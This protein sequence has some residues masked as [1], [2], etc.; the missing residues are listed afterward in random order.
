[1]N[2]VPSIQR[3]KFIPNLVSYL[4]AIECIQCVEVALKKEDSDDPR[5]QPSLIAA[6]LY[7]LVRYDLFDSE[8]ALR[9]VVVRQIIGVFGAGGPFLFNLTTMHTPPIISVSCS[10]HFP[11]LSRQKQA[12]TSG[13]HIHTSTHTNFHIARLESSFVSPTTTVHQQTTTII[14]SGKGKRRRKGNDGV[15]AVLFYRVTPPYSCD[16]TLSF[17]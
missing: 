7:F 9:S 3:T 10:L 5:K 12:E 17:P 8:K 11:Q 15:G 16:V 1:M 13:L 6:A 14:M 4:K 2:H